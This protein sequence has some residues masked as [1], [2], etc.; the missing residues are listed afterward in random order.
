MIQVRLKG[1]NKLNEVN[2]FV[3]KLPKEINKGIS[4]TSGQFMKDVKKSAKLRA[5]KDTKRLM[6]SIVVTKK[7]KQWIL[8]VQSPYGIF[9]EEG[10][11]PH[12]FITDPGR[13]GFKTNKLPLGQW[14]KVS[15]FTPFIKPALEHNLSKLAQ[16]LAKATKRATIKSG[17]II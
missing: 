11:K 3:K 15:K 9:Q 7:G 6:R 10:F 14:V 17:G 1:R 12:Y 4:N 5:P 8:E 16:K 13:P 2:R